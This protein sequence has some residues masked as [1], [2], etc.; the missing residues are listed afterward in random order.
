[1]AHREYTNVFGRKP[2][3]GIRPLLLIPKV[4]CVGIY[5]GGLVSAAALWAHGRLGVGGGDGRWEVQAVSVVFR[6]VLIPSLTLTLLLGVLLFLQH[7]RTFWAMRWIK[8]KLLLLAAALPT[9]HLTMRPLMVR[10]KASYAAA[11]T[12]PDETFALA[13]RWFSI[14]LTVAAILAAAVI[15]I[16]RHKPRLGQRYARTPAAPSKS[17][18]TE[19]PPPSSPS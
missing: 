18:R 8:L 3:R 10:I 7:T 5:F 2:G 12:G 19:P 17:P 11:N 15:F 13:C 9:L 1:M 4:L 6:W 14:E 16:G